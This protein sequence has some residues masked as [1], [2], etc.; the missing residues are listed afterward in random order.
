MLPTVMYQA[1][2]NTTRYTIA[3]TIPPP[4]SGK[5]KGE[6]TKDTVFLG[7]LKMPVSG[8]VGH[9]TARRLVRMC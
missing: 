1:V 3:E 4:Q 7:D 2:E 6:I 8:P 9:S 5:E